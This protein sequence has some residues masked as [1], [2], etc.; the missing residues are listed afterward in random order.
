[1]EIALIRKETDG[2]VAYFQDVLFGMRWR[3]ILEGHICEVWA[4]F[5]HGDGEGF[6][7]CSCD[8]RLNEW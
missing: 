2:R 6:R 1:M 5:S 8:C 4:D 7:K 3:R